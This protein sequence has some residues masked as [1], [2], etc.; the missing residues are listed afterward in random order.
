M[1]Y[2]LPD[3][4][5]KALG[6]V[7]FKRYPV[8]N[9]WQALELNV[10]QETKWEYAANFKTD[11]G[12]H[13][14]KWDVSRNFEVA[15]PIEVF[16][17]ARSWEEDTNILGTILAEAEQAGLT[18]RFAKEECSLLSEVVG[19]NGMMGCA[20]IVALIALILRDKRRSKPL[21]CP[22]VE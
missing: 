13:W 15:R 20:L 12:A 8:T 5:Q 22:D 11:S 14:P 17:V 10:L 19:M 2:F 4:T 3:D 21:D 1:A 9:Y 16:I 18:N 7:P 6:K